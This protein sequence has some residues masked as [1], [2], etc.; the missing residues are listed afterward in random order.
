MS[1]RKFYPLLQAHQSGARR[2]GIKPSFGG[3][4]IFA[5]YATSELPRRRKQARG[6]LRSELSLCCGSPRG[7][8]PWGFALP[9]ARAAGLV[10][11]RGV[12][13]G[14][15][16][17]TA[18]Q[19][20]L[21]TSFPRAEPRASQRRAGTWAAVSGSCRNLRLNFWVLPHLAERTRS[22]LS[23]GELSWLRLC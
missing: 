8:V 22:P 13:P 1:E 10:L 11:S 20:S 19:G 23:S 15:L 16:K 14:Q 9:S 7:N 6:G 17:I 3:K 21:R 5:I 18:V 2:A 4:R 12:P